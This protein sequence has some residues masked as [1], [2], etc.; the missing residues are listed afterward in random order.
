ME[1]YKEPP[2]TSYPPWREPVLLPLN[3]DVIHNI[4]GFGFGT[5]E[6][7]REKLTKL[8]ESDTYR[9]AC[10]SWLKLKAQSEQASASA[11]A[12]R[13][14]LFSFKRKTIQP[15]KIYNFYNHLHDSRQ[16]GLQ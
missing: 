3:E 15:V 11:S 8:V 9:E 2:S 1:G 7:I 10:E 16:L 13:R 5:A 4:A 6:P 14:S 12:R